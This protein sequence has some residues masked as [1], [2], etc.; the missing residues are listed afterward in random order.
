[1]ITSLYQLKKALSHGAEF[2]VTEYPYESYIDQRRKVIAVSDKGI[3]TVDADDPETVNSSISDGRGA[4]L[5]WG[6]K[7][8]FWSF[9][10]DG[11]CAMF[12]GIGESKPFIALKLVERR[13]RS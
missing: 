11:T 12:R 4:W 6:G 1:M 7:G 9:A 8:R 13:G 5:P 3:Y 2:V 10:E